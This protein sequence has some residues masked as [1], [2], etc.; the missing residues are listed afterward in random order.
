MSDRDQMTAVAWLLETN[1]GSHAL[2]W[3]GGL[4]IS[5]SPQINGVLQFGLNTTKDAGKAV[6]FVTKELA[7]GALESFRADYRVAIGGA[8]VWMAAEHMWPGEVE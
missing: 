7:E 3:D 6:R 5:E 8:G 1:V 2:Y 4:W